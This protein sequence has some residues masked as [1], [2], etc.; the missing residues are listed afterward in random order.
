MKYSTL[1]FQLLVPFVLALALITCMQT[2]TAIKHKND[3]LEKA[4]ITCL[5]RSGGFKVG[6]ELFI[7]EAI[8][9]GEDTNAQR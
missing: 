2:I 1:L 3:E 6:T 8:K 5:N 9:V 7:C 4:L